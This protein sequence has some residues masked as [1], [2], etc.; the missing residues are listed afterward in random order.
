MAR[1][2]FRCDASPRIGAGHVMRC[3][4]FA[5][6]L[7]WAGWSV[8][9]VTRPETLGV[10]P[11]LKSRSESIRL[12]AG[13]DDDACEPADVAIV[14]HYGLDA[15]FERRLSKTSSQIV[16][17]DDLAD[18]DHACDILVD[19]TPGR[20]A[21]A[22]TAHVPPSARLLLGPE[23][24][25]VRADWRRK[26]HE[27]R[28]RLAQVG[29]VGRILVM[30]GATDPLD[31][32]SRVLAALSRT[33][34]ECAVD[35][36]L[37]A[38][39]PYAAHVRDALGPRMRLHVDPPNLTELAAQADL[40]IGA[41]GS[42]SFER[43]VLGLPAILVA[44]AENQKFIAAAFAE[45]RGACVVPLATLDDA[46]AMAA[47]I[48]DLAADGPGRAAMSQAAAA[49][50]DGRG[51]LRLLTEIAG[52]S[53]LLDGARVRLRVAETADEAG[54]LSLQSEPDLRRYF[55]NP[56]VPSEAEHRAWLQRT[57]ADGERLLMIVEVAGAA[58]GMLRLDRQSEGGRPVY[59][60]S[61]ATA[62]AFQRRGVGGAALALARRLAPAAAFE[63]TVSPQNV[64][65]ATLFR[66]AG[67]RQVGPD[68]FRSEA[69]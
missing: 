44:F 65:S 26:S 2:V 23:Y 13:N 7:A 37:G 32:T 47:I 10:V 9:F 69:A 33:K 39:A 14:D 42:S 18:R 29:P 50:S 12:V 20:G 34:L 30:M 55:H 4:V 6:A 60:V 68:L 41:A 5:D 1:A 25:L 40:A 43:A 54:L 24:A 48:A 61:I 19:P 11:A 21:D 31:T 58:A 59:G 35:V 64:R 66:R 27:S 63:A 45:R 3:I 36:V 62:S 16:V 53:I 28:Q 38:G 46:D 67:Y 56:A 57:L 17:F 51:A 52:G 15:V 49:L 8:T 22:Y